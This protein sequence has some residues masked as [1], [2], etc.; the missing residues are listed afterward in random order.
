MKTTIHRVFALVLLTI[1]SPAGAATL[2]AM[3][4]PQLAAKSDTVVRGEVLG[5]RTFWDADHRTILSETRIRVD[6]R[7]WGTVLGGE[8]AVRS[9]GGKVG[10]HEMMA[11]GFPKFVP[12]EE[13]LLFLDRREDETVHVTGLQQG[14]YEVVERDGV[15]VLLPT[16]DFG[17]TLVDGKGN[18]VPSPEPIALADLRD[19]IRALPSSPR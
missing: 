2:V 12:G 17:I 5:V 14:H 6:E 15:E 19:Q 9:V 10:D 8:I 1:G 16:L 13:V 3:D 7:L 18:Q 4:L 11:D